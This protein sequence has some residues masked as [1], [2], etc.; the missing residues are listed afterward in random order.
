MFLLRDVVDVQHF[1]QHL[2]W[3]GARAGLGALSVA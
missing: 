3:L 2:D 1:S